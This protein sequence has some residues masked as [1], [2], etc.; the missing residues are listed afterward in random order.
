MF[1]ILCAGHS[2]KPLRTQIVFS[3]GFHDLWVL[4]SWRKRLLNKL[5]LR[6]ILLER[7]QDKSV[8]ISLMMIKKKEKMRYLMN[9]QK[10]SRRHRLI[11]KMVVCAAIVSVILCASCGKK[12]PE[13]L[14]VEVYPIADYWAT[15]DLSETLFPTKEACEELA[16]QYLQDAAKLLHMEGWWMDINPDAT[17]LE[18]D[19]QIGSSAQSFTFAPAVKAGEDSVSG[20]ILLS[21]KIAGKGSKDAALAHELTHL[22]GFMSGNSFSMSLTE[23]LCDYVQTEIGH[24]PYGALDIQEINAYMLQIDFQDE[25]IR[26]KEEAVIEKVGVAETGYPY[27]QG[28]ELSFWYT[29]SHSFVRYLIDEF[30]IDKVKALI[31]EGEDENSYEEILG[32]PYEGLKETWMEE[33]LTMEVTITEQDILD[34]MKQ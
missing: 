8:K 17:K 22:I 19:I 25:N 9:M 12:S 26:A 3:K 2:V 7:L 13:Y 28:M 15:M 27:G 4:P 23:G 24:Y 31:L 18:L 30:G 20:G 33:L 11:K 34:S 32:K 21:S 10:K 29:M 5:L 1:S 16:Q 6:V 14:E